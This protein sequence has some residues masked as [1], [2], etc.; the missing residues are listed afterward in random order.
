M[1]TQVPNSMLLT[2][3]G[4]ATVPLSATSLTL[5][6]ANTATYNGSGIAATNASAQIITIA[7]G[8]ALT[9]GLVIEQLGVGLV[10]VVASGVTLNA[11]NGLST[12]GA[13]TTLVVVWE[14]T[15][16]YTVYA[17]ATSDPTIAIGAAGAAQAL[18]LAK[19][20]IATMTLSAN[21]T[22]SFTG[23]VA[24]QHF[25]ITCYITQDGVTP[26]TVTVSPTPKW[27]ATAGAWVMSN[28]VSKVDVV[29]FVTLDG[30]TTVY[31]FLGG[32]GMV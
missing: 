29:T 27:D 2:P 9:S 6:A 20:N 11:P 21:L 17:R 26:R 24:G 31:G 30:G 14:S 32:K 16:V 10:S 22:L 3:G 15:D 8:A 13:R 23:A 5:N 12:S 25:A 4:G 1:T 7:A 28:T 18:D 19:Y